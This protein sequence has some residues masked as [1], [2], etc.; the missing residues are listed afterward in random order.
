M[1]TLLSVNVGLPTDVPWQGRTVHTGAWKYP[2]GGP[3]MVRRLNI[4]GDG[5]G[6]LQGHGG[7]QRAVLVYQTQSYA[8]WRK[9]LERDDL[10]FGQFGENFTVDGLADDEVCIGDRYLIGGAE[11]EVTQP[12]VTCYRVGMRLNEPRMASLL[13]AHHRP[14]FYLRVITEGEV[15]AGDPIT[16]TRTGKGALSVADIDALL[17]LPGADPD[18]LRAALNIEA[19][20]PG[21]QQSFREMSRRLD[22]PPGPAPVAPGWKGFKRLRVSQVVHETPVVSSFYLRSTDSQPLPTAM[23]GQYLSLRIPREGQPALVRSYSLSS[24]PDATEYRISVKREERGAASTYLHTHLNGGDV[25]E[26]AAPR[27]AF[28]LADERTPVA[29]FSAGIG[30]T[31]VLA[32]LHQLAREHSPRAV[33]WVHTARDPGQHAFA[34]EARRLVARLPHARS[35]IYYTAPDDTVSDH[36]V[37]DHTVPDDTVPDTGATGGPCVIHGRVTSGAV[38][39]LGVPTDAH[40]YL[41][42][43]TGFMSDVTSALQL[44]GLSGSN[45]HTEVFGALTAINPGVT[46]PGAAGRPHQPPG[47]QGTGPSVTFARSG[48]ST[49]WSDQYATLLEL[50]EGCDIP[51]RWSCRTGVCHTCTTPLLTGQVQYTTQPLEDPEPG[52]VLPCCSIPTTDV[53]LDL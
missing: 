33:W 41:C 38:R 23:P 50:A 14:G 26:A 34:E 18:K 52:E 16:R 32:M 19:L 21:W 1:A 30:V 43:P 4:D 49:H 29:L 11:F 48:L 13:V 36:A 3:R 20:S 53:L 10:G 40:A 8:Y 7:E 46:S 35:F 31:P 25:I 51:T 5:Q 28:V 27:G 2:V 39:E 37:P 24:A 9:V 17:Y 12:R 47:P 6:D 15:R 44:A 42:G 22:Q 45:I